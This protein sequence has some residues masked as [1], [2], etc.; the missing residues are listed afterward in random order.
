MHPTA[1]GVGFVPLVRRVRMALGE[2]EG[3][4][5]SGARRGL[6]D[7][8]L[9]LAGRLEDL[10]RRFPSRTDLLERVGLGGALD[11]ILDG[12]AVVGAVLEGAAR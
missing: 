1:A 7:D 9:A 12:E 10:R 3:R 4:G 2:T 8:V 5:V 11:R 6:R